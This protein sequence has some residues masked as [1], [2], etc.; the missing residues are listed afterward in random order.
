M[1]T[2]VG[3]LFTIF[4]LFEFLPV[5]VNFYVLFVRCDDFILNFICSLLFLLFFLIAAILFGVVR[6]GFDFCNSLVS[7]PANL[8]KITCN[9]KLRLIYFKV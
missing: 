8:L 5:P 6:V 4:L 9:E 1:I 3:K 7:L 2:Y